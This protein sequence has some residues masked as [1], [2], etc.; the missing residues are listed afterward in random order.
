M[1]SIQITLNPSSNTTGTGTLTNASNAY[2]STT[3]TNRATL[4]GSSTGT[5]YTTYLGFDFSSIPTDAIIESIACSVKASVNNA[6]RFSAATASLYLGTSSISDSISFRSTSDTVYQLSNI[7][8]IDRENLDNIQIFFSITK[9]SRYSTANAYI[10]GADLTITYSIPTVSVN[11][12]ITNGVIT[13]PSSFPVDV[14][15]GSSL[16]IEFGGNSGYEFASMT[17]NGT[18][19]T[20]EIYDGSLDLSTVTATT[21]FGTYSGSM[22][23][24][25]DSDDDTY[26]WSN[27]AQTVGKYILFTFANPIT[28]GGASFYSSNTTDYPGSNFEFQ[29]SSDNNTWTTVGTMTDGNRTE[30]T[31]LNYKNIKYA[32]IYVVSGKDKWLV[33]N[34]VSFEFPP[35]AYTIE[36]VTGDTEVV[37][38]YR[39]I[40]PYWSMIKTST[41]WKGIMGIYR[42]TSLGW[43]EITEDELKN[44]VKTQQLIRR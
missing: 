14:A 35:T 21:N 24:I 44:I 9:S 25:L 20:P 32:R 34:S 6:S 29:V 28:L 3:S 12:T 31:D 26:F 4:S 7:R 15:V 30:F 8:S 41:G 23:N 39:E 18:A 33:L 1:A 42:K 17:V 38:R 22:S 43:E 10:Y 37:I 5:P 36:S 2:A 11:A 27:E 19:V 16:T 13:S 40:R